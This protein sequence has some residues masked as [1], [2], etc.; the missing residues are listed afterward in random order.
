[1]NGKELL[2]NRVVYQR[3][4]HVQEHQC[5]WNM[6]ALL[7]RSCMDCSQTPETMYLMRSDKSF[8]IKC[9]CRWASVWFI[10]VNVNYYLRLHPR[11]WTV[12]KTARFSCC[13]KSPCTQ[14]PERKNK[15]SVNAKTSELYTIQPLWWRF[16]S[17]F[18]L[19]G[20]HL[21][22][23]HWMTRTANTWNS[24]CWSVSQVKFVFGLE[25]CWE[26]DGISRE[27]LEYFNFVRPQWKW[28]VCNCV[29]CKM[30]GI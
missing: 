12:M 3:Y 21:H 20:I 15:M 26:F 16:V 10:M 18:W 8:P 4:Q 28:K 30:F 11:S 14:K 19:I 29:K 23:M 17:L 7:F 22:G 5:E 2:T 6:N 9:D 1:M 24:K 27:K 25:G 13:D